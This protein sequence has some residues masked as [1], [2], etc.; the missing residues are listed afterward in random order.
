LEEGDL[1]EGS[2]ASF[3]L[4]FPFAAGFA[5]FPAAALPF[6]C[7]DLAAGTGFV[8]LAELLCFAEPVRVRAAVLCLRPV[9]LLLCGAFCPDFFFGLAFVTI[10]SDPSRQAANGNKNLAPPQL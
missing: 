2:F 4:D 10:A 6:K 3:P 5:A 8:R 9:E 1:R 7:A